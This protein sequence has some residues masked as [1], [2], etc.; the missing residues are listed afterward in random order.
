MPFEGF[1]TMDNQLTLPKFLTVEE[2]AGLLR[3]S[4]AQSMTGFLKTRFL[5][6]KL[7]A[8]PYS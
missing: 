4:P 7:A 1:F 3:V 6:A 5:T 2:V 8:V